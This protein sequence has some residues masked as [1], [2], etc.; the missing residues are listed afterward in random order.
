MML[1]D[2]HKLLIMPNNAG[3]KIWAEH[4]KE[5]LKAERL[6]LPPPRPPAPLFPDSACR[7]VHLDAAGA[8]M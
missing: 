2:R 5:T 4:A 1:S 3:K 8:E 6:G 7:V